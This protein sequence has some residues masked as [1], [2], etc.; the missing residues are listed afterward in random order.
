MYCPSCGPE[1]RQLS[2]YCRACG[3]DLRVVRTSLESPD[4][5]T[6]SAVSAREHI[7][8]AVAE[9]IRQMDSAK[10]LETI[11]EDVL[12]EFEKFLESPE[13]KRLRRIRAGII[14]ASVGLAATIITFVM[15]MGKADIFPLIGA[16]LVTFFVGLGFVINGFLFSIVRKRL[17]GETQDALMQKALDAST[18]RPLYE[19]PAAR[20]LTSEISPPNQAHAISVTEHTTHHL[21][22]R[23]S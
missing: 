8:R 6:A 16:G 14:T 12:P 19:A 11:A 7:G 5:I 13:E 3:T 4:A 10:D 18:G 15:A 9:K 22:N 1:E 17:P 20:A 2:Q 21:N 23:E